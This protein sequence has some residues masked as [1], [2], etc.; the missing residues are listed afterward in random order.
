[1]TPARGWVSNE[2]LRAIFGRVL[3]Y[4]KCDH[5]SGNT[6]DRAHLR[7]AG[8]AAREALSPVEQLE[9]KLHPWTGFA[10]M[11]IFAFANAGVSIS[12]AGFLHSEPD[13]RDGPPAC[14]RH[15][16][17][18]NAPGKVHV[19]PGPP[20]NHPRGVAGLFL[21]YGANWSALKSLLTGR[22]TG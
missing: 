6:A 13:N 4:P 10:I 11:P 15:V 20:S 3:A 1:M 7:Q 14:A 18:R 22:P 21:E 2:R 12:S 9:M 17:R 5:W 16:T 19:H 8:R